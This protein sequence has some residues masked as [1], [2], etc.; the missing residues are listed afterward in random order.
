[1]S[2]SKYIRPMS[3]GETIGS[4]YR[5]YLKIMIPILLLNTLI[6]AMSWWV[7]LVGAFVGPILIMTSNAIL[8]KPL[9][10]WGSFTRGIFS[11][12]F[13][14]IAI[15]SIGYILLIAIIFI[16]LASSLDFSVG[17]LLLVYAYIIL[18]PIWV[19]IPMIMLLEKK[20]LRASIKRSFQ[21]LRKNLSRILQMDIFIIA[22]FTFMTILG[23]LLAL[24]FETT[25]AFAVGS[26]L[27]LLPFL[28]SGFS[29]LP[30][31]FVY[32]EYRA[33]HENYSE[34]LLTEEM[35]YQPMEEMMSV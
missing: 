8:G 28:F 29:S 7:L 17:F 32:Y 22:I 21:I 25:D 13:L 34:E 9:K 26:I 3:F 5:L 23:S 12:A 10:V 6:V 1:M 15:S 20:G 19:F 14:K 33:R 18:I 31:V 24:L 27:A 30:Y 16:P 11:F 2:T 4:M 35:G